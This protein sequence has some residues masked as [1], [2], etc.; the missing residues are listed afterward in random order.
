MK[1][2]VV[3]RL[4][5]LLVAAWTTS[6]AAADLGYRGPYTVNQPLNALSW[7]GPYLGGNL[8]YAWGGVDNNPAKPSGFAGGA[9][10][11]YN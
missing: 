5:A 1:R 2:F 6:S 4:L 3:L 9:Q 11:G 7:A 10:V 8:G